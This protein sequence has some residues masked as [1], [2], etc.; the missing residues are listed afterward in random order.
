MLHDK[1]DI[2]VLSHIIEYCER[3][4]AMKTRFGDS[5]QA[6]RNDPE[7]QLAASMCVLQIGELAKHLSREATESISSIPWSQIKG[8]RNFFAHNY[9]AMDVE[10]TWET[11]DKEIPV[12]HQTCVSAVT[13]SFRYQEITQAELTKL[14]ECGIQ[15]EARKKSDNAFIIK[16]LTRDSELLDEALNKIRKNAR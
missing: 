10:Q 9:G 12:L 8:M 7:Y 3:I 13:N 6:F 4:A 2:S 1:R 5:L 14:S 16:F 15:F 11:I